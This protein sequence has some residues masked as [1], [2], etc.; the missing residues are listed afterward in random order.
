MGNITGLSDA[1]ALEF[2][3]WYNEPDVVDNIAGKVQGMLDVNI[4]KKCSDSAK[5]CVDGKGVM[6]I[7]EKI[8]KL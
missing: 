5:A 4:R 3:G 7:V 6:R 1:G 8:K 2:A